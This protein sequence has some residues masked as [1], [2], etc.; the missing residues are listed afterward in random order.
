MLMTNS[1]MMLRKRLTSHSYKEIFLASLKRIRKKK[2]W[3]FMRM[4]P[5]EVREKLK[6]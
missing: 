1:W 5:R 6:R 4:S 2:I 3:K